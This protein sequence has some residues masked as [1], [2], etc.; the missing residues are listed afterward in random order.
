MMRSDHWTG[1]R[2]GYFGLTDVTLRLEGPSEKPCRFCTTRRPLGFLP[3]FSKAE[4]G[5]CKFRALKEEELAK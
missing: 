4:S 1:R 5:R 3:C 2:G